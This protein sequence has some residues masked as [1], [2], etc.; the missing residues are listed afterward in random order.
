M[1]MECMQYAACGFS[2]SEFRILQ[3][4]NW[5]RKNFDFKGLHISNTWKTTKS[6]TKRWNQMNS[7]QQQQ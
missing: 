1:S 2:N 6:H 3:V 7:K 4:E 5:T